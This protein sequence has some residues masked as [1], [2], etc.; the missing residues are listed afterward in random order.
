MLNVKMLPANHGDCILIE[1]GA[2]QHPRR[3][4][5]DGGPTYAWKRLGTLFPRGA[6]KF[7]LVVITH[8]DFDHIGGLLQLLGRLPDGVSIDQVWFN[9][10]KHL[11]AT[12]ELGAPQAEVLTEVINRRKLSW[13]R[14]FGGHAVQAPDNG[15]LTPI[16]LPDG[17]RLTV[18]SPTRTELAA[19]RPKWEEEI[20]KAGLVE[21]VP[22]EALNKIAKR[23][24][25]PLDLLGGAPPDP[26]TL[27]GYAFNEDVSKPNGSSIVLLAEFEGKSVL[28]T[29][30][31]YPSVVMRGINRLL[32]ERKK[33]ALRL[34]ALKVSHHGSHG[35]TNNELLDLLQC[36]R[37]LISTNGRIYKHPHAE[38]VGRLIEHGGSPPTLYFNYR[39]KQNQVWDDDGLRARFNYQTI[40]PDSGDGLGV[41]L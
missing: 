32:R 8:I 6:L 2:D 24:G 23:E 29:G 34:D 39:S 7:E 28:L 20:R 38:T 18:L 17:L 14:T 11:P 15:E 40:Y 30:D 36:N 37:F 35:N 21:G 19:L 12:D 10:W 27:A 33:E 41:P 3:I 26:K 1:W 31:A 13:N 5:I 16:E 9:A 22:G 25:I 4:L